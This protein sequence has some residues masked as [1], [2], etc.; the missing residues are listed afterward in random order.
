MINVNMLATLMG[1]LTVKRG[2]LNVRFGFS[3][4]RSDGLYPNGRVK[5]ESER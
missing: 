5:P 1:K 3:S 2:P 4:S